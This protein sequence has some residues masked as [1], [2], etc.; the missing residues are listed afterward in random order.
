MDSAPTR[1]S[2][3]RLHPPNQE[4]KGEA[5]RLKLWV[6]LTSGLELADDGSIRWLDRPAIQERRERLTSLGAR[7]ADFAN[8]QSR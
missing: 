8:L 1:G 6:E 3:C 4:L 5:Q 7:L 2:L